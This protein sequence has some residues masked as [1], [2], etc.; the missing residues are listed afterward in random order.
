MLDIL[1]TKLAIA[2]A[3]LGLL[4]TVGGGFT[5]F[6]EINARLEAVEKFS[7]G[8]KEISEVD[9]KVKINIK[10]IELLKLQIREL[11]ASSGNPLSN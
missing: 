1:K 3:V 7:K 4:I 5:K 11:K 6:G 8:I 9:T 2:A 10:E